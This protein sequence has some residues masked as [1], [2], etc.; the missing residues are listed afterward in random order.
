MTALEGKTLAAKDPK[1]AHGGFSSSSFSKWVEI[2]PKEGGLPATIDEIR[3][4]IGDLPAGMGGISEISAYNCTVDDF[5]RSLEEGDMISR[6]TAKRE[7]PKTF[8]SCFAISW[9]SC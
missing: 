1:E 4:V 3:A 5:R 8:S 7:T 6:F 9:A 2:A